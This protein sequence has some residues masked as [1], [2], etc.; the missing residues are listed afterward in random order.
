VLREVDVERVDI[1]PACVAIKHLRTIGSG[2]APGTKWRAESTQTLQAEKIL[3]MGVADFYAANSRNPI[4]AGVL[5]ILHIAAVG[6]PGQV[7]H[8]LVCDPLGP[9]LRVEIEEEE[10]RGADLE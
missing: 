3:G 1:P 4:D 6:S 2:I 8:S 7:S 10:F 5:H 9:H